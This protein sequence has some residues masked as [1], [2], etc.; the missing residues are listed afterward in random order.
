MKKYLIIV[1]A[2]L[3]LVLLCDT[4][5]Y[6]AGV[7]I[8]SFSDKPSHVISKIEDGQIVMSTGDGTYEAIQIKGVN[9]GSGVPGYWSTEFH[10]DK[11]TYLRWFS[12]IQDMGANVIRIYTIL[13]EDFYNAFYEYNL[14]REQPLY[15]IQGVWVNDYVLNSHHNIY[16]DAFCENF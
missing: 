8:P 15:L 12:M 13:S 7:Y 11:E 16:D 2:L 14:D 1:A 4:L 3:V 6:R 10:V 5:Y 9:M